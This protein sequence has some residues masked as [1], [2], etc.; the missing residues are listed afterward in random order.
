MASPWVQTAPVTL[1]TTKM[2]PAVAHFKE[3]GMWPKPL[4]LPPTYLV[5]DKL[6]KTD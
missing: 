2:S 3:L 4:W 6:L 5:V 1:S